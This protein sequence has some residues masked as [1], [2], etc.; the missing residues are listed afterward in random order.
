MRLDIVRG[1]R[2]DAHLVLQAVRKSTVGRVIEAVAARV[3]LRGLTAGHERHPFAEGRVR[4]TSSVEGKGRA[5]DKRVLPQPLQLL[6]ARRTSPLTSREP[7]PTRRK[8]SCHA[9]RS[10]GI[11]VLMVT[12]AKRHIAR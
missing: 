4:G 10:A 1:V 5:V 2:M 9:T 6:V 8:S 12:S 7:H 11:A 3:R